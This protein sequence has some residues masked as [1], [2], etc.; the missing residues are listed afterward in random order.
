MK[1][2]I[3]LMVFGGLLLGQNDLTTDTLIYRGFSKIVCIN[4]PV[5]PTAYYLTNGEIDDINYAIKLVMDESLPFE[6]SYAY[7]GNCTAHGYHPG[8]NVALQLNWEVLTVEPEIAGEKY[9]GYLRIVIYRITNSDF[10]EYQIP[11]T[12]QALWWGVPLEVIL[13]EDGSLIINYSFAEIKEKMK[14]MCQAIC[15]QIVIDWGQSP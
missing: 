12:M 15:D 3:N 9:T 11:N 13:Y 14:D 7:V 4:A 8:K 2:A 10:L 1:R 5:E 6:I